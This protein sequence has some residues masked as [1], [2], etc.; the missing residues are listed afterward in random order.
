[1][2]FLNTTTCPRFGVYGLFCSCAAVMGRRLTITRSPVYIV[3]SMLGPSTLK[4]RSANAFISRVPTA[5]ATTKIAS[6]I[7]SRANGW[8]SKKVA[9]ILIIIRTDCAIINRRE[10][11]TE[12]SRWICD[13]PSTAEG[14]VWC[15]TSGCE[16][17][18]R[19]CAKNQ[20]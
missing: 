18:D 17:D 14:V 8:R 7:R 11:T 20:G 19:A 4:L 9:S 15:C 1:M 16:D 12:L 3:G 10:I 6:P 2:G 5:T 13:A